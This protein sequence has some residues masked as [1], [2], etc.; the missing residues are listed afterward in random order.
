MI[1]R[2][3]K[4]TEK[5]FSKKAGRY[6]ATELERLMN[7]PLTTEEEVKQWYAECGQVQKALISRFPEF[8]FDPEVWHFFADADIRARDPAAA[9]K[10]H[11]F[12]TGYITALRQRS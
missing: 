4:E 5:G 12:I 7:M 8:E 2:Q 6:L 3:K 11:Q 1:F 10:H 9:A